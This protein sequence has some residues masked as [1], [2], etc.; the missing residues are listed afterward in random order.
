MSAPLL[1]RRPAPAPYFH[2]SFKF[3][4]LP[5]LGEL[6]KIYFSP[7]KE[8]GEGGPNYDNLL[9][10]TAILFHSPKVW[11]SVIFAFVEDF[12][13]SFNLYLK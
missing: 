12:P 7:L 9:S 5:P 1:L 4:R 10:G 3:F 11:L 2:T 8:K 13:Y 6:I